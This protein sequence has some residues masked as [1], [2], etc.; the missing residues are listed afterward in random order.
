MKKIF[1]IIFSI[2]FVLSEIGAK[3]NDYM[4][5]IIKL[6]SLKTNGLIE[7][8]ATKSSDGY[9][10]IISP[11]NSFYKAIFSNN[12][13]KIKVDEGPIITTPS[14]TFGSAGLVATGNALELFNSELTKDIKNSLKVTPK[15]KYEAVVSFGDEYKSTFIIEP[16][17]IED[18]NTHIKSSKILLN[19]KYDLDTYTGSETLNI[20]KILLEPKNRNS[21]LKLNSITLHTD[22]PQEPVDNIMLFGKSKLDIKEVYFKSK[23]IETKFTLSMLGSSLRVDK[24]LLDVKIG[25]DISALDE[26]TIA[27]S[28]GVKESKLDLAFKNLGIKGFVELIKLNKKL[29]DINQKLVEASKKGDDIAMQKAILQSQ[30]LANKLVPIWNNTLKTNKSK[31]SLDL[32]LISTKKSYIKLDLTYKGKPLSGDLQSAMISVAAQQLNLFDGTFDIA[33]DSQLATTINPFA[34][35]GLDLLKNKNLAKFKDGIYYLKG[36]LKG[37]KIIINGKAYTISELSKALF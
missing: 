8:N 24:D 10:L 28:K 1:F 25:Y 17:I 20:D 33:L 29:E 30:E 32:E 26:K 23:N 6:W 16:L 9:N 37:G 36:Q 12:P 19:S 15:Y 31:I 22:I 13:I 35:M 4:N 34:I 18:N 21:L 11:K 3:N 5:K 14:F 2:T 27:L 7:F